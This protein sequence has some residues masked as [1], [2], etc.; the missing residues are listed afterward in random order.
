MHCSA[1]VDRNLEDNK[2]VKVTKKYK[3]LNKGLE[4]MPA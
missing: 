1:N 2:F 4:R 3:G